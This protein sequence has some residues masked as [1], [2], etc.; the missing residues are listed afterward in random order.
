MSGNWNLESG[1][2]SRVQSNL[3]KA[4]RYKNQY[5]ARPATSPLGPPLPSHTHKQDPHS[6]ILPVT[7]S[8]LFVGGGGVLYE[9]LFSFSSR[10]SGGG[11]KR[12]A[13]SFLENEYFQV[14]SVS[15][16]SDAHGPDIFH[17]STVLYSGRQTARSRR[18]EWKRTPGKNCNLF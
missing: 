7:I 8:P 11:G 12:K 10:C 2:N 4:P 1:G 9:L 6:I 18:E 15:V 5:I 3:G 13:K 14:G 16:P 17:T